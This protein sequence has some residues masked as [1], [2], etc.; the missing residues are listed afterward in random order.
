MRR[1]L[2]G[3]RFQKYRVGI[4]IQTQHSVKAIDLQSCRHASPN[5]HMQQC[6]L[7]IV[8]LTNLTELTKTKNL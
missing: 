3:A 5:E 2:S 6:F 8:V 7:K 4:T 1:Y